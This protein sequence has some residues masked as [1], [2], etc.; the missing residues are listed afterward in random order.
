MAVKAVFVCVTV[1]LVQMISGRCISRASGPHFR[2]PIA[3]PHGAASWR[4]P[5]ARLAP[6]FGMGINNFAASRGGVLE[7][8]SSSPIPVT[9]ISVYSEN[10]IEGRLAVVGE[11]PFLG[12][13]AVD[14][15]LPTYG[16]GAVN[17]DSGNEH[18]AITREA[19]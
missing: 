6:R 16:S 15:A 12:T 9:G 7:V 5:E 3:A 14:G 10:A 1:L 13:V 2:S 18:V 4:A 8:Y 19:W 17:Y 11:L